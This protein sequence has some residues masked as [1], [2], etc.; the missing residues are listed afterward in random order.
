MTGSLAPNSFADAA[1]DASRSTS[2][3]LKIALRQVHR[4]VAELRRGTPVLIRGAEGAVL[5]AAAETV[6]ASAR[7][8]YCAP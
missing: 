3:H 4:A 8:G 1:D 6:G 7:V 2:D 5:V